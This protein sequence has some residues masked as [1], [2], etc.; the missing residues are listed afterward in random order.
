MLLALRHSILIAVLSL[1]LPCICFGAQSSN[2]CDSYGTTI[3]ADTANDKLFLCFNDK[4]GAKYN[5]AIGRKGTGKKK[6]GDKKTPLG[7]YTLGKPRTSEKYH[8]FITVGY[9]TTSQKEQGYTGGAIGLHGPH[10]SFRW[11]GR[12]TAWFDWTQGCIAV[13]T[14]K[15]ILEI[16]KWVSL[17]KPAHIHIK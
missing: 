6:Q 1:T 2:P 16:A 13:G 11:L 9:P 5:I 10:K 3:I 14:V 8:T 4:L 7:T 12:L 15:E 17:N